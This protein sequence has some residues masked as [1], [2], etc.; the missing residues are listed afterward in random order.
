MFGPSLRELKDLEMDM[1][2]SYT[3]DFNAA[4][5]NNWDC[6]QAGSNEEGATKAGDRET[7]LSFNPYKMPSNY[8]RCFWNLDKAPPLI[9][10]RPPYAI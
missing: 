7:P 1:V 6:L 10:D 3:Q 4:L 5:E 9:T 2:N 8:F